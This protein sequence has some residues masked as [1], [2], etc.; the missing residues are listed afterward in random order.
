[1]ARVST[2]L[3]FPGTTEAAFALYQQ[4]FGTEYEV[5]P[6]R[7]DSMPAQPGQP[8]MSAADQQK[9][10]HVALPILGGHVIMGTDVLEGAGCGK[11]EPGNQVTL[12]LEPDS[13]AEA[14]RLYAALSEG[15]QADCPMADMFWG[16]YW[17]VLQDRFGLRW[18]INVDHA[19]D[20]AP[21]P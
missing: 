8:E 21:Q 9:I 15:G 3:N 13:R 14:E 7:F 1:M 18:M 5:A 11:F 19:K 16:A 2:Y 10:L 17:G 12:N 20:P 4:V 6:M